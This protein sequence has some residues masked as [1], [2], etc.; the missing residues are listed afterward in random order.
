MLLLI[1]STTERC[2]SVPQSTSKVDISDYV[3][4]F[5]K[6]YASK[7]KPK[8]NVLCVY[9]VSMQ[10]QSRKTNILLVIVKNAQNSCSKHVSNHF[11]QR[12]VLNFIY[13]HFI[14]L[15]RSSI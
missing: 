12:L 8:R 6:Y 4:L 9:T 14:Y 5:G 15:C 11:P 3:R 7:I 13:R 2:S 10:S 1:S